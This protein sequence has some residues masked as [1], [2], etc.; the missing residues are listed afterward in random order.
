MSL[1][2][3]ITL[4][5][6]TVLRKKNIVSIEAK[7]FTGSDRAYVNICFDCRVPLKL[8][9]YSLDDAIQCKKRIEEEVFIE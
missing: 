1:K 2:D 5:D 6:G 8:D 4:K 7:N 3:R 9:Y